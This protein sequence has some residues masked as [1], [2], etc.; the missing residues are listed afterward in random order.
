M[1]I[2]L[3]VVALAVTGCGTVSTQGG[4]GRLISVP[5]AHGRIPL[6][7]DVVTSY[8]RR[9][10][11]MF[12]PDSVSVCPVT[13]PRKG[14]VAGLRGWIVEVEVSGAYQYTRVFDRR[15]ATFVISHDAVTGVLW[16]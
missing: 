11:A 9:Q 4:T 15:V 12:V 5:S 3:M 1:K 13:Y 16:H 14:I 7:E 2:L 8:L 10:S 6:V